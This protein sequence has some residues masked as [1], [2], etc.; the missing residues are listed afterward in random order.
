MHNTDATEPERPTTSHL[1][2][3]ACRS[4][5][6]RLHIGPIEGRYL[7]LLTPAGPADFAVCGR[8][9]AVVSTGDEGEM[10][11]AASHIEG[12]GAVEVGSC[13]VPAQRAGR[14]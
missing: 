8:C 9:S 2:A 12:L 7:T 11:H 5:A 10:R 3:A 4:D 13:R 14:E 6:V 1:P